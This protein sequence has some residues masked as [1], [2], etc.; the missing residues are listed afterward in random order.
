M[1]SN[2]FIHEMT[3]RWFLLSIQSRHLQTS[4]VN[5]GGHLNLR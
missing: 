5:Q 2:Q 4:D 1:R 3:L